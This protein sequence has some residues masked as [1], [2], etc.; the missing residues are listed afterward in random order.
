ME[1][2]VKGSAYIVLSQVVLSLCGYIVNFGLGR[3]FG[4]ELYGTYGVLVAILLILNLIITYGAIQAISKYVSENRKLDATIKRKAL[5]LQIVVAIIFFSIFFFGSGIIANLFNDP[6]LKP[7]LQVIAVIIP[8]LSINSVYAG[9]FNGSHRFKDQANQLIIYSVLR[10]VLI[11]VLVLLFSLMGVVIAIILAQLAS[12]AYGFMFSKP[13]SKEI[14]S[15]KIKKLIYFMLPVTIF[16]GMFTLMM[17]LDLFMLKAMSLSSALVGYYN[18]A[19]VITRIPYLMLSSLAFV[20]LPTISSSI[21]GKT[22]NKTKK[23]INRSMRYVL[24]ILVPGTLI[25]SAT[26]KNLVSLFYKSTYLPASQPFS[27]LIFG[28]AM[29]TIFY[30]NSTIINAAGRPKIPMALVIV[31]SVVCFLLNLALIPVLGA[32]GAAF[33][34]TIT[35]L[36]GVIATST[37]IYKKFGAIIRMRSFLKIVLCSLLVYAIALSIN[38]NKF[39]LPLEYLAL[40]GI[41]FILLFLMRGITKE[42]FRI[43]KTL[44]PNFMLRKI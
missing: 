16:T 31:L 30:L 43:L 26:S 44:I 42:D 6:G 10:L 21:A 12:L 34:T 28:V 11:A 24:I 17:S 9:F 23:L 19:A 33:A 36:L 3:Y 32:I 2:I 37:W 41:Y 1:G 27:I 25:A 39:L 5:K 14:Y 35:A 13:K 22:K 4:P 7:Y 15:F 38:L 8:L 40:F 18:A 29:L 20:L